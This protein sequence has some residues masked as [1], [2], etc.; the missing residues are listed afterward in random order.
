M[1]ELTIRAEC[2]CP[3]SEWEQPTGEE[4]RQVLKLAGM[5]GGQA[6]KAVGLSSSGDRTVR[7]W[8]GGESQIPYAA[9]AVLCDYAGL[10]LIW[11]KEDVHRVLEKRGRSR[12]WR[13]KDVRGI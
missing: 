12:I 11:R 1:E 9:W 2:L 7:R 4:V 5:T 8:I 3:A 6:A 10:G 13:K